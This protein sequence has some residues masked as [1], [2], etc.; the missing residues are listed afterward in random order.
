M[1]NSVVTTGTNLTTTPTSAGT[2]N[3]DGQLQHIVYVFWTPG[4]VGNVLTIN[5]QTT[6]LVNDSARAWTPDMDWSAAA[7]AK[8]KTDNTY[9][10]T[11]TGVTEVGLRI[12]VP[13]GG[14]VMRVL[15]SES[16]AGG[17]TKGSYILKIFS[18]NV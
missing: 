3:I 9:T 8:T 12:L 16:E 5:P 2:V 18:V 7:G 17:A 10:H 4:T 14:D 15:A 1:L 6:I 11:A 13:A